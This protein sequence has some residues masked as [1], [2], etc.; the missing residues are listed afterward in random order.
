VLHTTHTDPSDPLGGSSQK[1][2]ESPFVDWEIFFTSLFGGATPI[3][4]Q[5][6]PGQAKFS[7]NLAEIGF[8]FFF[9]RI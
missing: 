7:Q 2:K 5:V 9:W 1:K 6:F 4:G 8:L 3:F